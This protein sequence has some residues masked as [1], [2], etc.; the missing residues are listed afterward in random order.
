MD[1]YLY[2]TK[3]KE[4]AIVIPNVVSYNDHEIV[5]EK[6]EVYG[7]FAE[8]LELS[9]KEDL[10]ETRLSGWALENPSAEERLNQT[11][12]LLCDMLFKRR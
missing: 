5:T 12:A 3:T 8:G 9:F 6:N 10:S 7:P 2:N 1:G 11:E 4:I